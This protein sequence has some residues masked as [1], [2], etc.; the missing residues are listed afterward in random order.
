MYK[1]H[2]IILNTRTLEEN[3][4]HN[5]AIKNIYEAFLMTRENASDAMI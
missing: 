4:I 1:V 3:F 5:L 2:R